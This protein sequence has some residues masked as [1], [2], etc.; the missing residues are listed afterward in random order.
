[1]PASAQIT[2]LD[3]STP[4]AAGF[5]DGANALIPATGK[6]GLVGRNGA[7]KSTLFRLIKGELTPSG[8]D[9]SLPK[10]ARIGSVDQETPASPVTCWTPS[11]PPTRSAR[12]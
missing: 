1:V 12:G 2:D 6:V 7:G 5:F 10:A 11:W 8:G 9:I 4:T 3:L